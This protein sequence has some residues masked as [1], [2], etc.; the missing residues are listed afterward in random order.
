MVGMFVC[1]CFASQKPFEQEFFA[2]AKMDL[3][4]KLLHPSL[5]GKCH[6]LYPLVWAEPKTDA[7]SSILYLS[8][9]F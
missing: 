5:Y 7:T 4:V 2:P 3:A 1:L 8:K 9:L 6:Q